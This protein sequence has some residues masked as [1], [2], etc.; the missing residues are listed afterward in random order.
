MR[1]PQSILRYL[2]VQTV[3]FLTIG[4]VIAL[5]G[6]APLRASAATLQLTC[7][8]ASL[9]FGTIVSSQAESLPVTLTNNGTTSVTVSGMVVS[10]SEFTTSSLT[11]P[12]V[13]SAGQSVG[14]SISFTPTARGWT[15]GTIDI[16]STASNS[17]LVLALAGAGVHSA[18]ATASPSTVSF[19]QVAMGTSSTLPVVLTNTKSSNLTLSEL[20]TT[21][22]GFSISGPALPLTLGVR[23]SVTL[24][25][26]FAPQATGADAGILYVSGP[27]VAVPLT[28]TGTSP[29]YS[30]NLFW[31][32]SS[33]VEGYNVYRSTAANGT[34]SKINPAVDSGTAY[35]DS[36][37]VS[38]QT[39][40]Y[41]ATSV[42]AG[43]ME[44]AR[45][46]PPV[47][48]AIP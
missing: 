12:L 16:T 32:S 35:T 45:S 24:S 13:L 30:V 40:Y 28:G 1:L 3:N 42:S 29:Q 6:I 20:Q 2:S 38:G 47:Q 23:Q 11:L 41:A 31:T 26:T 22:S 34:Y 39:Y 48:V 21:G 43:G 10:S 14:L 25:V 9:D 36:T 33:G 8:P 27:G 5:V 46:T 44:S 15:Y 17:K 37:V 7:T 18:F 19:G 4:A